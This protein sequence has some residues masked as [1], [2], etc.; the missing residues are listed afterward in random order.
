MTPGVAY[1][2]GLV[3]GFALGFAAAVYML[4]RYR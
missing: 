4:K 3:L 2:A 1:V